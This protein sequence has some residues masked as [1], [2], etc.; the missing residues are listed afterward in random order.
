MPSFSD[1]QLVAGRLQGVEVAAVVVGIV[2]C[3]QDVD[4][5]L[6]GE[7]GNGGGADVLDAPGDVA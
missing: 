7:T 3:D 5:R 2:D 6:G 4:D 1:S